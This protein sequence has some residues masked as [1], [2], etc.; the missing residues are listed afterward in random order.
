M[1]PVV[2]RRA[3]E[4]KLS[5]QEFHDLEEVEDEGQEDD[6]YSEEEKEEGDIEK[7]MKGNYHYSPSLI[8][9]R[10]ISTLHQVN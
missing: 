9:K 6:D 10:G 5:L 1:W 8:Q 7:G 4:E 2:R 3:M